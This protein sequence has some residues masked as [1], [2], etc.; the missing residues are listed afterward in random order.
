MN[1]FNEICTALFNG[2]DLLTIQ[3]RLNR[4][5]VDLNQI[6]EKDGDTALML[7]INGDGA[8]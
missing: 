3:T 4:E 1:T 7:A 6:F 5:E 2:S 8:F